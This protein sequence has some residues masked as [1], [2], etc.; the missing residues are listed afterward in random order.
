MLDR[1]LNMLYCTENGTIREV[2]MR[3]LSYSEARENLKSVMDHVCNDHEP[4][5]VTRR[6]GENIVLISQEDYESFI[7]TDYLLSSRANAA[8]LLESLAQAKRGEYIALADV[9]K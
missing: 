9:L 8:H 5:V 7:E 3:A 6:R 2:S 4:M 1:L